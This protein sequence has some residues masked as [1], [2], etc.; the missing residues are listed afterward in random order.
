MTAQWCLDNLVGMLDGIVVATSIRLVLLICLVRWVCCILL[1]LV[2]MLLRTS[3][4]LILLFRSS[5]HVLSCNVSVND[6]VLLR[7]VHFPVGSGFSARMR[8]L[9]RGFIRAMLW[10]SLLVW[11]LV[12]C[13]CRWD[14]T[15]LGD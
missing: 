13:L 10:V 12:T 15:L 4:G 14:V 8:L 7:D 1:S 5:V 6:Y 2:N 3:I 9:W 11:C